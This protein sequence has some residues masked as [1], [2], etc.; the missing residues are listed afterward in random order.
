MN[1]KN[2][3]VV[4]SID[5]S[6]SRLSNV[7]EEKSKSDENNVSKEERF[8]CIDNVSEDKSKFIHF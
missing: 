2:L 8:S 6:I 1:C 3:W 7:S 4:N 5:H